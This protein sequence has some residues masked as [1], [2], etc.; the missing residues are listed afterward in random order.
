MAH[1]GHVS[2]PCSKCT[3]LTQLSN[4][5]E[6][7]SRLAGECERL[8]QHLVAVEETYT[9]EALKGEEREA[10]LRSTLAKMEEKLNSHSSL[11]NSA[12]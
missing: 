6:K 10:T 12:R 3:C 11:F 7:E 4:V 1:L 2:V 9:A 5:K 8:R